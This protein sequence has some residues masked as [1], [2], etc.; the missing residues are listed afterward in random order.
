MLNA[1]LK[2]SVWHLNA[3]ARWRN[4]LRC[5]AVLASI[6]AGASAQSATYTW[7]NGASTAVDTIPNWSGLSA[8][9]AP[10]D[11]AYWDGVQAGALNL[12][13]TGNSVM[14]PGAPGINLYV[15]SG[16]TSPI[17]INSTNSTATMRVDSLT[18]NPGAGAFTFGS[19]S[20]ST[21]V[22]TTLGGT[23]TAPN[24][25]VNFVNNS[26]NTATIGANVYFNN[27]SAATHT[28]TLGGSGAWA[29]NAPIQPH[30]G[31]SV[32]LADGATGVVTYAG[33]TNGSGV[34][35]VGLAAGAPSTFN[36]VPAAS[37]VMSG[38][39]TTGAPPGT[40]SLGMA[41]GAVGIVNQTGGT[42]A[43]TNGSWDLELGE[44]SGGYGYYNMSAGSLY[45]NEAEIGNDGYGYYNQSGGTSTF[46]NYFL[47]ARS[48]SGS[49]SPY[50]VANITGG[51][52]NFN[53]ANNFVDTWTG[54]GS[55]VNVS[56]S[57]FM[58]LGGNNV[59]LGGVGIG[60]VLNVSN[61]GT[62]QVSAVK[63]NNGSGGL[64]LNG[65]VMVASS[66]TT[67][68]ITSNP[69]VATT[70]YSS[71]GT[72][73]NN[74]LNIG[75]PAALMAPSGSGVSS[76]QV[77]GTG[78]LAPPLVYLAGN[79][80]FATGVATIDSNGN[81]TGI[82]ITNPG[83]N[84]SSPPALTLYGGG[85]TL[86]SSTVNLS[87]F[88]SGGMAFQGSGTTNLTG[89]NTYTGPTTVGGG[90]LLVNGNPSGGGNY[91]VA[92]GA[93]LGGSG[94]ITNG[95][96]V[97]L[98]ASANLAPGNNATTGN[99]GTLT[100]PGLAINGGGTGYF[101]I[102]GTN[103]IPGSGVNDL[104]NVAGNI[105]LAGS[106]SVFV[107][108]V[109][110]GGLIATSGTSSYALFSYGGSVSGFTANSFKL[111]DT[112]IL[113]SRQVAQFVNN[114]SSDQID[115]N[116]IGVAGNLT[117]VGS[118]GASWDNSGG[119]TNWF[120]SNNNALD[121]FV[122]GD[123]V[124]F[125]A[126][127]AG[128]PVISGSG[129]VTINAAVAPGSVT[130]T[131]GSYTLSGTGKITGVTALTV[132]SGAALTIANTNDYTGGTFIQGGLVT[133]AANNALPVGGAL[134]N[135]SGTLNLAGYNQQI[136]GLSGFSSLITASSGNSTLTYANSAVYSYF[137]GTIADA[138][139]G[140]GTLNLTVS[141]GTLD[142]SSG[143][144]NYFG[145]T[146]VTGSGA[147]FTSSI[148]NTS[149]YSV[150]PSGSL[151]INNA[152]AAYG[153][154]F[155]NSGSV[156]FGNSSG[157]I[158][159][160]G[161]S[162][163]GI[164][165][166]N[167]AALNVS[168]GSQ[169]FG[170]LAA[171]FKSTAGTLVLTGNS[172]YTGGTTFNNGTIQAGPG[173]SQPNGPGVGDFVWS[174][175]ANNAVLDLNGQNI[176][177]GAISQPNASTTNV[178]T[179][180]ASG[181][182]ATLTVGSNGDTTTFAGVLQN[183]AGTLAL[184]TGGAGTFTLTNT[185]T[186]TGGTS[187]GG[188][189]ILSIPHSYSLPA[190]PLG[191]NSAGGTL[192]VPFALTVPSMT[193][194]GSQTMYAAVSAPSLS[195]TGSAF[196]LG[197][198]V[199]S[200]G[201][202]TFDLT[203]V[204]TFVYSASAQPFNVGGA[205]NA[206]P[207]ASATMLL[208]ATNTITAASFG[209]G[210]F[211][212]ENFSAQNTGTVELGQM[213]TINASSITV[214]YNKNVGVLQFLPGLTNP[215]LVI[216]NTAGNGR[217]SLVVAT[218]NSGQ[219]PT[220]GTID[221]VTGVTGNSILAAM[222]SS[223]TIGT[224]AGG[225]ENSTGTF[226]MG[227]GTLDATSLYVGQSQSTAN[228]VGTFSTFGGLVKIGT[229][230]LGD[231]HSTGLATGNFTLDGGGTLS[232]TSVAPGAGAGTQNFYWN[233]G[234][235][236]NYNTS[237]S[238]TGLTV[239]I[240]SITLA[241]TGTH[242]LWIDAG[243]TGTI[244]ASMT[245][246]GGAVDFIKN[247]SG[248]A[249]LTV[250]NGYSGATNVVGGTLKLT[251]TADINGS[252]AVNINSGS[253]INDSSVTSTVPTI[254]LTSGTLGGTGSF[255][256]ATATVASA[257]GNAIAAGD[258]GAGTLT[259]N[260]LTFSG[261]GQID[262]GF[263][264]TLLNATTLAANGAAHS[265]VIQN[266][267]G[268][269][270]AIGEYPLVDYSGSIGGTGSAAFV[271]GGTL[272]PRTVAHLDFSNP[273][274]IDYDVTAVDYPVWTGSA[275][276]TWSTSAISPPKNWKLAI[277]GSATDF[278]TGDNPLFN[279]TA[280]TGNVQ[281]SAANVQPASVTFNNTALAYTITGPYGIADYS[282]S[283][284]TAVT[285]NGGG[286][287]V[288]AT[289]NSYTGGT[290]INGGTLQLGN[291]AANGS[292]AG[293]VNDNSV[294]ALNPA[295]SVSLAGVISGTGAVEMSGSGQ[296]ILS[297]ANQYAGG[298]TI[299]GG[300]LNI[301]ADGALGT[302]P[303]SAATN[304][305][306]NHNGTLQFGANNVSLNANRT[307]AVNSGVTA[308]FDTYG[309]A[310]TIAGLIVDGTGSGS[311]AVV[312]SGELTLTGSN[313]YS[314]ATYVN[315][316][317]LSIGNGGA[318]EYLA[319]PSVSDSGT[320]V[321]NHTDALTYSGNISGPGALTHLGAGTL[322]LAGSNNYTGTTTFGGGV[323]DL[324]SSTALTGGGNITFQGG[325]LQ[326]SATGAANLSGSV[327]NSGGNTMNFTM[328][329]GTLQMSGILAASNT[330][331]LLVTG[332][333]TLVLSNSNS[334]SGTTQIGTNQGGGQI[335]AV[336]LATANQALGTGTIS[337]DPGGNSTQGLLELANNISLNNPITM[338][339]RNSGTPHIENL[340]GNNTLSGGITLQVG[341]T[342]YIQSD[343]GLLT[344]SSGTAI[345]S[346]AGGS[347]NVNLQGNGNGLISG[348]VI[349]GSA[350][351]GLSLTKLGSGTWTIS[352]TANAYTGGSFADAGV[353]Q[354]TQT[355]AM[356]NSGTVTVASG[357]I[358]AVNAGGV[359]EFTNAVG[360]T[361]SIGGLVAGIGGQGAPVAWSGGAILGI[362]ATNAPGGLTYAGNIGNT[363]SGA[364]GLAELGTGTLTLTGT[365]TYTGGTDVL[366]GTLIAA[367]SNAIDA[368]GVGTNLSVGSASELAEFGTAFSP[369]QP[370]SASAAASSGVAPVPEPGTLALL[371][372]GAIAAIA[373]RR[374]RNQVRPP[375]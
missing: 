367:S 132:Q 297:G 251:G 151:S 88:N 313:T 373:A 70:V 270:T 344:I 113:N 127:S 84:Y 278:M 308:T 74:G 314:G 181:T 52:L 284:S 343:S 54:L 234:T 57:G 273:G 160:N 363:G 203:A 100:L 31:A 56:G 302:A 257:L 246:G 32:W 50:G 1:K 280:H 21:T 372:A 3:S 315:V 274:V 42:V 275:S 66:A 36:V 169:G 99:V 131:G 286:L 93:T 260:S 177:I 122:T 350:T 206:A 253:F 211:T 175:A 9:F 357:A 107:N 243:Q 316:A 214:G 76:I 77:S 222:I 71:G 170:G 368:L 136:G 235:I 135:S 328:T 198:T 115:L 346:G 106:T 210:A 355:A 366:G 47:L 322:V 142:A 218:D 166:T 112:G 301:N 123:N 6:L 7:S 219:Q 304:V 141:A 212:N 148:P 321:F 97:T 85:G 173:S 184:A 176:S 336:L 232:A 13:L 153:A 72:I 35:E 340:S 209:V 161:P 157:T 236:A 310:A 180:S 217:A 81:L 230:I 359:G 43:L 4:L 28:I 152:N 352:N 55:S 18:I 329:S 146:T 298:T 238:T 268:F 159:M 296:L 133:L 351:G 64:N 255:V 144:T 128:P 38:G 17:T 63:Y 272:P 95:G 281:I 90:L 140:G 354:F 129:I 204:P 16:Q 91:T 65:G 92:A 150:G 188:G 244:N 10:G 300:I 277:A 48:G 231:Q 305:T 293:A 283:Q 26:S 11:T 364:L 33:T 110:N 158:A 25:I 264:T 168:A 14:N 46:A 254:N 295:T 60:G 331:G 120:N 15:D 259:V 323:V 27:S 327:V 178:I 202:Q 216:R 309:N 348:M 239:S 109:D 156:N 87:S 215:T 224:T 193:F 228:N 307:I 80:S 125:A 182:I 337:F 20:L 30:N 147:L 45:A 291:G 250:T 226:L 49:S 269:P 317:T 266:S 174:N 369:I 2:V 98:S 39:S 205:V 119:T 59:L 68:F 108:V 192:S 199:S 154:N 279:D 201:L 78:F 138:A 320:L 179:N 185:N 299:N 130:A 67:A 349:N 249:L 37:L 102:S 374:R 164:T 339:G 360:G 361:G 121:K 371:A 312:G 8:S 195:V 171:L 103:T 356:P 19:A 118:N 82:T 242:T 183:G 44:V 341:G 333:G 197:S 111:S 306:F 12:S 319:S 69:N 289:S 96:T 200:A 292:I 288:L 233:N 117:W 332:P 162:G 145:A 75:I 325:T 62:L 165:S 353:L 104:V 187:V 311:I 137:S 265:V 245:G 338:W 213:N 86:L 207:A 240:P 287:V 29:F 285:L 101:D 220:V 94:S 248:T 370:A 126:A 267:G 61:G 124:A 105:S 263:G 24:T 345:T 190:G 196:Q 23:G 324:P 229:L 58:S 237:G 89:A 347:R 155:S 335:Y 256:S 334:Y 73:N 53:G 247:G 5:I 41:N 189:G 223:G 167:G 79:G 34:V 186:Y 252:S 318:G 365:N 342:Y 261:S 358:L 116:I 139:P 258:S 227:G 221:L 143:A 172:T 40:M 241:N 303:S 326:Y 225:A 163:G 208:A 194:S 114:T 276:T 290:N 191:F 330:G 271:L 375:I 282:A 262:V 294:L 134:T 22:N 83:I 362:D 51:R 149:G